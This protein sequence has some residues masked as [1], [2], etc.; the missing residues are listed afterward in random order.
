M[1]T[2]AR[3]RGASALAALLLLATSWLI[4]PAEAQTTPSP[5]PVATPT[6]DTGASTGQTLELTARPAVYVEAKANRDEVFGA[7]SQE[8]ARRRRAASALAL[9][10][11]AE[12]FIDCASNFADTATRR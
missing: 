8:V 10:A 9:R 1:K 4:A 12:V 2:S 7:I 6:P 3:A 5:T 11:L